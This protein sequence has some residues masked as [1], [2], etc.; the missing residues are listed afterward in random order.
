VVRVVLRSPLHAAVDHALLILHVTGRKS[1][2]RHDIPVGYVDLDGRFVVVT[3]HTWRANLRGGA[4]V[5]VTQ[6]GHRRP[7]HADLVEE[8]GQVAAVLHAVIEKIGWQAAR[9]QI[10]LAVNVNRTPTLTELEQAARE[11]DLATITLT[12]S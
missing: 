11:F 3:Q 2:R 9:R 1:G 10:G 12:P 6:A 4:D 7:M 5:E 8:P